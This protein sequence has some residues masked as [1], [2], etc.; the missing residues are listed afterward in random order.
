MNV[1]DELEKF[2]WYNLF[3]NVCSK[4]LYWTSLLSD[5][6]NYSRQIDTDRIDTH[7]I[8]SVQFAT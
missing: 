6:V 3:C 5:L 1:L 2:S 8:S 7:Q 4:I